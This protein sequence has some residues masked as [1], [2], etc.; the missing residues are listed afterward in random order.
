MGLTQANTTTLL[1][2]R[3]RT[4]AWVP[5]YANF[6]IISLTH[7]MLFTDARAHRENK[8]CRL[9]PHVADSTKHTFGDCSTAREAIN[10]A[11]KQL[12]LPIIPSNNFF[13]HLLGADLAIAPHDVALRTMLANSIWRARA[14][15][16]QGADR[17]SIGWKNWIVDDCLT[18]VSNINPSFFDTNYANNTIK[19]SYKITR[20]ANLGSSSGTPEQKTIASDSP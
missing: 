4:P 11:Y 6:V 9:C 15:A 8:G 5:N 1:K 20:K 14:E 3:V 13:S 16:G 17:D 19:P 7:N 10:C 18:R 2:N 12:N